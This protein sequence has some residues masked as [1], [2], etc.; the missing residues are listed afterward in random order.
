MQ[1]SAWTVHYI[2]RVVPRPAS[3]LPCLDGLL[4]ELTPW[5]D[6]AGLPDGLPFLL[7]PR[8]E[9]DA[10]LNSYFHRVGFIDAP[11]NSNANRA[12]AL[13]SFL[14][15]LESSRRGKSWRQ[16]S[17][18]DHLAYHQWR[19]RDAAGPRVG[20]ST[21]SQE[22]SHV[23][24][25]YAWA[26][27]QGHVGVVPIP[28][29]S[30]RPAPLGAVRS[31]RGGETVPATYAHDEGGE[32]IEWLPPVSYRLWRDVGLRATGRTVCLGPG[33]RAAG[34]RGTRRSLTC[35]SAL[36]CGWRSRRV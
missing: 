19:R 2:D 30:R 26:V 12:R 10:V 36:A 20:G 24:Q 25:F 21:W 1:R 29:R 28:H 15:F 23:N 32:R 17:E 31:P 4:D 35:W 34:R 6:A 14:T 13:A 9:Y 18:A 7:S 8:F 16:A 33:S 22:V 27:R 5:L 11:W 3:V